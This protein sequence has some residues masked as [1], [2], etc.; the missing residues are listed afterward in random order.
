MRC[1]VACKPAYCRK[2]VVASHGG[3]WHASRARSG[4]ARLSCGLLGQRRRLHLGRRALPA[5]FEDLGS[6]ASPTFRLPLLWRL[7]TQDGAGRSLLTNRPLSALAPCGH[8]TQP[9]CVLCGWRRIEV[10]AGAIGRCMCVCEPS[11]HIPIVRRQAAWCRRMCAERM[12]CTAARSLWP[13]VC[14]A[15]AAEFLRRHRPPKMMLPSGDK[16]GCQMM[17]SM[18]L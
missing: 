2:L 1:C 5:C 17:R 15:Q 4:G 16:K 14:L 9:R 8:G 18:V 10:R 3:C 12:A 6:K 11:L 13:P 7:A